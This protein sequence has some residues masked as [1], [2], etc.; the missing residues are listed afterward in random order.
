MLHTSAAKLFSWSQTR[1]GRLGGGGEGE[2]LLRKWE[3]DDWGMLSIF[4]SHTSK[5]RYE[6]KVV[7]GGTT[8][9]PPESQKCKD[10]IPDL[11]I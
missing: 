2:L 6:L 10:E 3:V 5:A 7:P 11:F 1:E 9:T 4:D 8:S